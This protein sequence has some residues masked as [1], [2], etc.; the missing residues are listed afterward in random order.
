[1]T[2]LTDLL[3]R[4]EEATGPDRELDRDILFHFGWTIVPFGQS[5]GE[6][7]VDPEGNRTPYDP[8][9]WPQSWPMS[10]TSS[11]DAALSLVE[12]EI[13]EA[14]PTIWINDK[15]STCQIYGPFYND[16]GTKGFKEFSKCEGKTAPLAILT[17]LVKS[18]I[19]Q[20]ESENA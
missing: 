20:K 5:F 9:H 16:H 19:A 12:R 15:W 10:L 17:A 8:A 13:P 18:V 2:T 1:M 3:Q 4:L 11:I 6:R 14:Q 7:W